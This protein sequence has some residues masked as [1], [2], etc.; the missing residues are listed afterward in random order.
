MTAPLHL[1]AVTIRRVGVCD[2]LSM[3]PGATSG[4]DCDL[5]HHTH[6]KSPSWP[7]VG[8][9]PGLLHPPLPHCPPPAAWVPFS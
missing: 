3:G 6:P 5:H 7:A 9:D 4:S 8:V 1:A 2:V